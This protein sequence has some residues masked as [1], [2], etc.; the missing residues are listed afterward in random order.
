MNSDANKVDIKNAV[1]YLFGVMPL[2]VSTMVVPYKGRANRKL[3]R[4]SFKKAIVTI[5]AG[6]SLV[7]DK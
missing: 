3:V 2:K 4:R 5:A 6:S 1:H 7:F